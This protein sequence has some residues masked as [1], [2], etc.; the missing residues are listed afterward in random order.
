VLGCGQMYHRIVTHQG[1]AQGIGIVERCVDHRHTRADQLIAARALGRVVDGRYDRGRGTAFAGE[2]RQP[3]A[4]E[5]G[6]TGEEKA[7]RLA[8]VAHNDA[9]LAAGGLWYLPRRRGQVPGKLAFDQG[10]LL[11]R[12]LLGPGKLLLE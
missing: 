9:A 1:A 10:K 5:P 4:D 6:S 7:R 2:Q 12:T 11:S 8:R 3:A